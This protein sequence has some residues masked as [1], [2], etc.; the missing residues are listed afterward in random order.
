MAAWGIPPERF[1]EAVAAVTGLSSL[2][3]VDLVDIETCG[4]KMR[5]TIEREGQVL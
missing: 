2:F 4:S 5:D 3:K 1:Y